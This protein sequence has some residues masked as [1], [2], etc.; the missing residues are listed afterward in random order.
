[1]SRSL[2]TGID[3]G[4]S[5]IRVVVAEPRADSMGSPS[6]SVLGYGMGPAAGMRRGAVI[7][8]SVTAAS[9][10]QAVE[11]AA[12]HAGIAIE[13]A[14]VGFGGTG[15]GSI[16]AKAPMMMMRRKL[17]TNKSA[18]FIF[19]R[20][21]CRLRVEISTAKMTNM[22]NCRNSLDASDSNSPAMLCDIKS[23]TKKA[24]SAMTSH[25]SRFFLNRKKL[26]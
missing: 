11:K 24:N 20:S 21:N 16:S 22:P 1:M 8:V 18:G 25:F 15:F 5:T 19:I 4:T 10:R 14:Y 9:I 23:A 12:K 7:D 17:K 3:V 13:H 6:F 26:R 2:I